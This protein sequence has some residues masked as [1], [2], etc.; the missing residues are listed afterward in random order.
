MSDYFS[1]CDVQPEIGERV[2]LLSHIG[3]EFFAT[4]LPDFD[5]TATGNFFCQETGV[6]VVAESWKPIPESDG[7]GN[8]YIKDVI[9]K[10][11][12]LVSLNKKEQLS[13]SKLHFL[14]SEIEEGV[15]ELFDV[16]GHTCY[17][18]HIMQF[19][20]PGK[21]QCDACWEI[22]DLKKQLESKTI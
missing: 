18:G 11:E 3:Q 9:L 10:I 21:W 16:Y 22:D 5:D 20:R 19:V 1:L 8:G 17:R 6:W 15:I 12:S 13:Q 4:Y 2:I 7:D 14:L